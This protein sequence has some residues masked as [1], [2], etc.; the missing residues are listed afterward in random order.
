MNK[1]KNSYNL[2]KI[3]KKLVKTNKEN[4][5]S[6]KMEFNKKSRINQATNL[7]TEFVNIVDNNKIAELFLIKIKNLLKYLH[8]KMDNHTI[9]IVLVIK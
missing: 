2:E 5:L 6:L 3:T 8:C 9:L 4:K 1:D 7:L